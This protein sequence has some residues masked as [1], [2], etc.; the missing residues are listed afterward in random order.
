MLHKKLLHDSKI[1]RWETRKHGH[2]NMKPSYLAQVVM[3]IT[4][5]LEVPYSNLN[6][7]S[8]HLEGF[9][10]FTQFLHENMLTVRQ[11]R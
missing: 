10:G 6:R 4:G 11:L 3:I 9:R 1:V 7:E 8:G 5:I 2:V